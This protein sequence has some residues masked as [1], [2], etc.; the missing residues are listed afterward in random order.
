M[1]K[2][3]K[4][5][6]LILYLLISSSCLA[7][8]LYRADSCNMYDNLSGLEKQVYGKKYDSDD[9]SSR[10]ERLE[11]SLYGTKSEGPFIERIN[12][13]E[14]TINV[15]KSQTSGIK[16]QVI[17]ELL[18]NR[19]FGVIYKEENIESRLSRLEKTVSGMPFIGSVDFRFDNL[20]QKV[21]LSIVGISVTGSAGD[22]VSI[23]PEIKEPEQYS[24]LSGLKYAAEKGDY[25]ENILKSKDNKI[26]RWKDFPVC[27]NI[28]NNGDFN[29]IH[30]AKKAVLAWNKYIQLELINNPE[31]ANI[32]INWNDY[33]SNIIETALSKSHGEVKYQIIIN[34]GCY[35]NSANLDRFLMHELG[36][37]VGIWGH[38][39]NS[40]DIMY[41]F[42]ETNLDI[43]STNHFKNKNVPV[44]YAPDQPSERDINTLIKIYNSEV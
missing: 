31:D 39:D 29:N 13:L 9:I 23:K 44:N 2:Y 19:Y 14:N 11:N 5:I 41:N 35:K 22:K 34:G 12:R 37:A 30:A 6:I 10:L 36:H 1:K 38:S 33:G 28:S 7:R 16:Q 15:T 27:V 8:D 4:I 26:Q 18:E 21:P 43:L 17:L 25:F 20:V 40:S 3:K 42:E 24:A 32:I